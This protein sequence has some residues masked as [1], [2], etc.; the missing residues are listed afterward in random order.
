MDE[1]TFIE[2]AWSALV[3]RSEDDRNARSY[4]WWAKLNFEKD[5]TLVMVNETIVR[6]ALREALADSDIAEFLALLKRIDQEAE[7]RRISDALFFA[8]ID[9]R[10]ADW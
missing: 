5:K 7:Q 4:T 3:R 2:R 10:T 1:T 8:E 6:E 9:E